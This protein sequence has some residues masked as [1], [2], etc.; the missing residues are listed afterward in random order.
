MCENHPQ[1]CALASAISRASGI[2]SAPPS[3]SVSAAAFL[4]LWNL[5]SFQAKQEL[6]QTWIPASSFFHCSI[7]LHP[8]FILPIVF[9]LA[10]VTPRKLLLT[11]K[12]FPCL[13]YLVSLQHL[14]LI[15]RLPSSLALETLF[16]MSAVLL[17]FII[18][19]LW[20]F[21]VPFPPCFLPVHTAVVISI[22]MLLFPQLK[23]SG[24]ANLEAFPKGGSTGTSHLTA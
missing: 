13:L 17:N 5:Q 19:C 10:S 12:D 8:F 4:C 24:A 11:S 9:W 16:L 15:E 1:P 2:P 20:R 21:L 14:A 18:R 7:V 22:Y 6:Y 3:C 23:S